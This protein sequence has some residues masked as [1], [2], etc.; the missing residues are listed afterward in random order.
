MCEEQK[1]HLVTFPTGEKKKSQF[2]T[3]QIKQ[4]SFLCNPVTGKQ[5]AFITHPQNSLRCS[6]IIIISHHSA[7]LEFTIKNKEWRDEG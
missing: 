5:L 2:R 1:G 6:V 4:K 7:L 3:K